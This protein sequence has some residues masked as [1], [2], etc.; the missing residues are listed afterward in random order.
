MSTK[1]LR[2]DSAAQTVPEPVVLPP[3]SN[4]YAKPEERRYLYLRTFAAAAPSKT[5]FVKLYT[6]FCRD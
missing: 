2:V 3:C 4:A 5:A 1:L 6:Q